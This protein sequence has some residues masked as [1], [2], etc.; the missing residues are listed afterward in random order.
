MNTSKAKMLV[1]VEGQKDEVRIMSHLFKTYDFDKEYEI[2][3][4]KTNIYNLYRNLFIDND[5]EDIDLLMLLRS[6]EPNEDK[7]KIFDDEY[8]DIILIFDLEVQDSFYS[9]D[10]IKRMKDYFNESTDNGK[11]YINYPMI[12]SFYNRVSIPDNNFI[13]YKVNKDILLKKGGYKEVVYKDSYFNRNKLE[14][15]NKG[16]Y[17]TIIKENIDKG[18]NIIGN[19]NNNTLVPDT[20]KI[21][22][23]Q[24]DDY[25]NNNELSVLCT[26]IYFVAE[27]N[28]KLID[29]NY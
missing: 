11:L 23:V 1:L 20:S 21:L 13:D 3:S 25:T 8:T 5:P 15:L 27:Y 16:D 12:E 26:C 9:S 6:R 7:K 22:D 24:I 19:I 2:V 4:Y 18:F 14:S 29:N 28:P 10:K 17:N